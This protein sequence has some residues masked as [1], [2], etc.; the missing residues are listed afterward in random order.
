MRKLIQN[1]KKLFAA[2]I[3]VSTISSGIALAQEQKPNILLIVS[4]DTGYGDLGPYGGGIGRG[5]PTPNIDKLASDGMTFF[6]FYAQPSC[7]PGRAAMQTGRIPNRSGMTTVAFQGQ[8]GGLPAAEW[9]LASVLKQAGYKTYFTGKWH[10]G[11]D[12]YAL[13]NAQGYDVMEHCFLYHCNAYTYGDPTWFP[14]MP[15]KLRA[16]FDKVTKGSMSGNAG[17]PAK[18]D[19]KVNGQY[20]NTPE[21]GVVGIPFLDQYVENAGLSF[22]EDAAKNPDQPFFININFMKVHQPN[23]PA[24]EF[25]GKSL[26]K[27]KYADSVVELD[28]RIGRVMDKLRELNLDENTL[29]F[30][31]TDNGAWQDVYPDAGYTPFRGTKGTVREGGNRVPAIAVWPGKIEPGVRN[32]DIVGGL[33]F[34]ATFAAVSGQELPKNDRAGEPIYFDSIDMTPVLTGT[35]EG[36]RSSW[37]YFTENELSPGAIRISNYKAVF[38]LRGDDGAETGGLAVDSN[39]G[40]KGAEKYVATV[41]QIFDLRQDPQERYDIFM[42]NYTERTWTLVLFNESLRALMKTYVEYPPRKAQ[43]GTYAGPIT[44]TQYQRFEWVRDS[45]EKDG[46]SIPMPTGN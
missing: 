45:L 41:P 30:Y 16:M 17:E 32:H 23:L 29:V 5:M 1:Y 26:S 35:G 22:L 9:T 19:W 18:E 14:D 6:S 27:T 34:M 44:L 43:S 20:V 2:T 37:F 3:V 4:D 24:P 33:D 28:T 21:K 36:T 42:N 7:T 31:T 25:E 8:G 11:E 15:P 12:D 39:L 38:N 46:V 10:L 40:W 13:P